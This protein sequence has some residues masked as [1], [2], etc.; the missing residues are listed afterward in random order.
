MTASKIDR[1]LVAQQLI[2]K[3]GP[4]AELSA[5]LLADEAIAEGSPE[6][7]SHWRDVIKKIQQL[8]R[9]RLPNE[10]LN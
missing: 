10:L 4:H 3:H 5:A 2:N 1:W 6:D 8:Q 9:V 7:E